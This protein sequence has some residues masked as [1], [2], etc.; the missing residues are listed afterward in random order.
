MARFQKSSFRCFNSFFFSCFFPHKKRRRKKDS[1]WLPLIVC[2]YLYKWLGGDAE[3]KYTEEEKSMEDVLLVFCVQLFC[4]MRK[5]NIMPV[6]N[7]LLASSLLSF[8]TWNVSRSTL[9]CVI[10]SKSAC[11]CVPTQKR[12]LEGVYVAGE[13]EKEENSKEPFNFKQFS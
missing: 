13:D 4:S 9:R 12:V 5:S 1:V 11:V 7:G 6:V 3:G 8:S 10:V 2:N